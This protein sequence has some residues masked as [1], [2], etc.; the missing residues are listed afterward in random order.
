MGSAA[1]IS[2]FPPSSGEEETAFWW[3]VLGLAE[4]VLVRPCSATGPFVLHQGD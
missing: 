3:R 4:I 1:P 2:S